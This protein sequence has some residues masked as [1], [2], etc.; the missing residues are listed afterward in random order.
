MT[1]T[2]REFVGSAVGALTMR[3]ARGRLGTFGG[4]VRILDLGAHCVFRESI[5]GYAAALKDHRRVRRT[6]LIVPAALRVPA[7]TLRLIEHELSAGATVI[8]E[9][10]AGFA[11][12]DTP[13]F[14]AHRDTLRDLRLTIEPPVNLWPTRAIPYVELTWPTPARVR[15]FSRVVPVLSA[16]G[17]VIART[18]ELPVAVRQR[19]SRGTLIFLGSP[20]GTA[21]WAGDTEADRWFHAVLDVAP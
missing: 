6:V 9:S 15:D 20:I 10:G 19:S 21:L 12:G 5:A 17:R 18:K 13:D 7:A 4:G 11:G 1:I 3:V 2:R 8:L 16:N 14:L